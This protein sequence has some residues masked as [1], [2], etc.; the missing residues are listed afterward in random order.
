MNLAWERKLKSFGDV[1]AF[2][3]HNAIV[4]DLN[5]LLN[6]SKRNEGSPLSTATTVSASPSFGSHL[7]LPVPT[8]A[9]NDRKVVQV[10]GASFL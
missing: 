10:F 9:G 6:P 4:N 5:D 2:H 7:D 1:I 8:D 3:Q